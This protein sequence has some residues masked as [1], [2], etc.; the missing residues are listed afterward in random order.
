[1]EFHGGSGGPVYVDPT[2]GDTLDFMSLEHSTRLTDDPTPALD[3]NNLQT[4]L[5]DQDSAALERFVAQ[6][7][8]V[9]RNAPDSL[10]AD[11][12]AGL[13]PLRKALIAYWRNGHN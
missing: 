12:C 6:I 10:A 7:L 11:R 5:G 4:V 3:G 9:D 8:P 13:A 1:M 2:T